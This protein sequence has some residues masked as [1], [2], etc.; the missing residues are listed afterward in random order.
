[1]K[2]R[3]LR[4]AWSVGCGIASVLLIIVWVYSYWSIDLLFVR[5]GPGGFQ[6]TSA[7]G[8]L[9]CIRWWDHTP[10]YVGTNTLTFLSKWMGDS[11]PIIWN[12]EDA[13]EWNKGW[14]TG[15]WAYP[16]ATLFKVPLWFP[17]MLAV[18]L[19]VLPLY[20]CRPCFS[21]RTLL[22]GMTLVA[23]AL[24]LIFALSR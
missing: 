15:A 1:M 8:G 3:K 16:N 12:N 14:V 6:F 13:R 19:T 9:I 5:S 2:Y 10:E 23:V 24:G 17:A 18:A 22:I 20:G 4:I 11:P 7:G 21:L